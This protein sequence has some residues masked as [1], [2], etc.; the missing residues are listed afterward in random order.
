[1]SNLEATIEE[2]KKENY[3]LRLLFAMQ[4]TRIKKAIELWQKATGKELTHPDLG[5]MIRWLLDRAEAAKEEM[6]N[7]EEANIDMKEDFARIKIILRA[8]L[9]GE[10][11][12]TRALTKIYRLVSKHGIM[13]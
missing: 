7:A 8:A 3:G 12:E 6:I 9:T 2:L 11:V 1:M 10:L 13:E 5:E 4:H